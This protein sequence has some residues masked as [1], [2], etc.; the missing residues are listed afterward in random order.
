MINDSKALPVPSTGIDTERDLR[1]TADVFSYELACP[2]SEQREIH[3][4]K[5]RVEYT[6]E[7]VL[8]WKCSKVKRCVYLNQ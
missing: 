6:Y 1:T 8:V 2:P 5:T 3:N 4:L 7:S